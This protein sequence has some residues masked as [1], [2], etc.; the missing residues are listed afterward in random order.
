[1]AR[2]RLLWSLESLRFN[3]G[4]R[5]PLWLGLGART[6]SSSGSTGSGGG[7]LRGKSNA[8]FED[9]ASARSSDSG[10]HSQVN[11]AVEDW[12]SE[13][14]DDETNAAAEEKEAVPS[15]KYEETDA[16]TIITEAAVSEENVRHTVPP[17]EKEQENREDHPVAS[18][19][20][21]NKINTAPAIVRDSAAVVS[22]HQKPSATTAAAASKSSSVRSNCQVMTYVGEHDNPLPEV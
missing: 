20:Y 17:L 19:H 7:N 15:T 16:S 21:E 13:A 12:E 11:K 5:P 8:L 18:T 1:M 14:E 6:S 4:G 22:S 9:I 2:A 3:G 10:D